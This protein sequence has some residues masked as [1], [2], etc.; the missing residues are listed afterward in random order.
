MSLN[1]PFSFQNMMPLNALLAGPT[2]Q[3]KLV[4]SLRSKP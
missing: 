1:D 3:S 2:E 4:V